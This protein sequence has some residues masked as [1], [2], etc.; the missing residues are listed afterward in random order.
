RKDEQLRR[1]RCQ[2]TVGKP[3]TTLERALRE[4]LRTAGTFK[5]FFAR[6]SARVR[7]KG[8]SKKAEGKPMK[9]QHYV[10]SPRGGVSAPSFQTAE[11]PHGVS[12]AEFFSGHGHPVFRPK[13]ETIKPMEIEAPVSEC[14]RY[15]RHPGRAAKLRA[16]LPPGETRGET[17]RET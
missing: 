15:S 1:S 7:K 2:R 3:S 9:A 16:G 6:R 14:P 4:P 13:S 8:A 12:F 5:H 17:W 11:Q 10:T